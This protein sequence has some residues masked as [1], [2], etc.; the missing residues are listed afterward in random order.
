MFFSKKELKRVFYSACC[1]VVELQ[2]WHRPFTQQ[3]QCNRLSIGPWP[4]SHWPGFDPCSQ[5]SCLATGFS[6]STSST[7]LR[8]EEVAAL[9]WLVRDTTMVCVCL[10]TQH[11]RGDQHKKKERVVISST[12]KKHYYC[13]SNSSCCYLE[14][15][16]SLYYH[17][18][19]HKH[20][21]N[22]TSEKN[23]CLKLASPT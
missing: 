22:F 8:E 3:P 6:S 14:A 19:S 13:C 12:K 20:N 16:E 15:A 18:H 4:T 11:K 2:F 9:F 1:F 17:S 7:L 21:T 10:L 23:I 5:P